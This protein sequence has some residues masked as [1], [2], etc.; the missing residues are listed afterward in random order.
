MMRET[1]MLSG[2]TDR[3][4]AQS[5]SEHPHASFV[6]GTFEDDVALLRIAFRM[7]PIDTGTLVRLSDDSR[8]ICCR[9]GA[10]TLGSPRRPEPSWWLVRNGSASLGSLAADGAF[11]ER[12]RIQPGDWL[13]VTGALDLPG[14]W[15]E[16]VVVHEP[17]E[18][19]AL[20]LESL[21]EACDSDE[22]FARAFSQVLATRLGELAQHRPDVPAGDALSAADRS[23]LRSHARLPG[24]PGAQARR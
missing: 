11:V 18:L 8:M 9:P 20:P 2:A 3:S 6:T 24:D 5:A 14:G 19:L 7:A 1:D 15:A 10:F 23:L 22:A 13:D 21:F 16:A 12:R 4:G 17:L